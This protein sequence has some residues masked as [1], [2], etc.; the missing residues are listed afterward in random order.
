MGKKIVT[1][2]ADSEKA[3]TLT[4]SGEEVFL[5]TEDGQKIS[6]PLYA[7]ARF[8]EEAM[9]DFSFEKP[10]FMPGATQNANVL[11]PFYGTDNHSQEV[12]CESPWEQMDYVGVGFQSKAAKKKYQWHFCMKKNWNECPIAKLL[13]EKWGVYDEEIFS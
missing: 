1:T 3:A 13:N 2:R 7:L 5:T 4:R 9:T 12:H 6:I 11:C 10:V 8:C